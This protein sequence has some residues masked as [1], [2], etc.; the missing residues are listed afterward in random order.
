M[1]FPHS[2]SHHSH[3]QNASNAE[4]LIQAYLPPSNPSPSLEQKILLPVPFAVPQIR[5]QEGD[6]PT[7]ARGHSLALAEVGLD[8]QLLLNF[9]DGLNLA[10]TMSSPLRIVATSG[11]VV[12]Y[13]PFNWAK[14]PD[15]TIHTDSKNGNRT[16]FKTPTDYYLRAA[17][18]N[19][20][21]PRGLVARVCTTSAMLILTRPPEPDDT[22][23]KKVGRNTLTVAKYLPITGLIVRGAMKA[24][25]SKNKSDDTNL[26]IAQRRLAL[27]EGRALP[28]LTG[29]SP[30]QAKQDVLQRLSHL[31][32]TFDDIP[33]EKKDRERRRAMERFE[34]VGLSN[35][36]DSHHV[37]R[38]LRKGARA[39]ERAEQRRRQIGGLGRQVKLGLPKGPEGDLL[40]SDT[41]ATDELLWIVIMSVAKDADVEDIVMA[42]NPANEEQVEYKVWMGEMVYES[43]EMADETL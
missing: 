34:E 15:H 17:N 10:M 38:S 7:F 42:E 22:T 43:E 14:L 2:H 1:H 21:R 8:Q 18:L 3:N 23:L 24:M 11:P 35:T 40:K 33:A 27:I 28:L 31:G 30:P 36:G 39:I 29:G 37:D 5:F 25:E 9:I 4:V 20:F 13:V 26:P 6:E 19:V 41:W 32:A 12:G 16:L